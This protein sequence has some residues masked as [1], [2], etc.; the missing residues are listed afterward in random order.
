MDSAFSQRDFAARCR[1]TIV[2]SFFELPVD[3]QLEYLLLLNDWFIN[4]W[5][6]DEHREQIETRWNHG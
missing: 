2:S 4:A 5:F 1:R 3:L 6:I